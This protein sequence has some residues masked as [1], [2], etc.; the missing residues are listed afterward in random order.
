MNSMGIEV[1][2]LE[3][4]EEL[5]DFNQ[6]RSEVTRFEDFFSF[7][8]GY[9]LKSIQKNYAKR[10]FSNISF[11]I[12]A[13]TGTGKTILGIF[14]GLYN[15]FIRNKRSL[16]IFPTQLLVK[17]TFEIF[18]KY[19]PK[20][21][22]YIGSKIDPDEYL[23]FLSYESKSVKEEKIGRLLSED[24]K[25]VVITNQFLSRRF[26][27]LSS[28][29]YDYIFVD[30]L[31]SIS[32]SSKNTF[33]ILKLLGFD[34][35]T[36]NL[37][38]TSTLEITPELSKKIADLKKDIGIL[39]ISSATLRRGLNSI[40]FR[41]LLNF[42]VGSSINFV[43]NIDD[44]FVGPK[45]VEKLKEILNI[46]GPGG[47]IFTESQE[48]ALY[49]EK[50][51]QNSKFISSKNIKQIDDLVDIYVDD[52]D[53][54]EI[55]E[56]DEEI[57]DENEEEILIKESIKENE[58]NYLIGI[59]SPYSVL[60]RGLDLPYKIR[61]VVFWGLPKR[62]I[63]LKNLEN[64]RNL[65][66][67]QKMLSN[68]FFRKK[69]VSL[70]KIK[71]FVENISQPQI[72]STFII[73]DYHLYSI[74]IKT[75]LQASG[76]C[77]RITPHGITKGVSFIFDDEVFF[78]PL[79]KNAYFHNFE[80][81]R[82]NELD[83]DKSIEEINITR[84][85]NNSD[86]NNNDLDFKSYLMI[87]ESPTK[88]KQIARMFGS[89]GITKMGN[90]QVFE[91]LSP[92]GILMIVPSMGHVVEL[93]ID[94]AEEKNNIYNV[95]LEIEGNVK[96][97]K[98][99]YCFIR[100]CKECNKSFASTSDVCIYCSSKNLVSTK[101][102]INSLKTLSFF[103]DGI[104][105]A[106]DPDS[107]GEKISFDILNLLNHENYYRVIFNEITKKAIVK[108]LSEPI[109]IRKSL[110]D[111]QMVRRIEDRW[112]G[113][114]LSRILKEKM[115][116]HNISAGRVQS[117]AL[118]WIVEKYKQYNTKR[119]FAIVD[120]FKIQFIDS[121]I[122]G[123]A[124]LEIQILDEYEQKINV[125]PF[126]TS[127]ILIF[128][129]SVLK[130][131]SQETMKILQKLFEYGLITYHRT[132]SYYVSDQGISIAR[133]IFKKKN[134]DFSYRNFG[135]P[136][137][138]EAIRITKPLEPEDIK[139]AYQDKLSNYDIRMYEMIY[140]RF[141]AC[142]TRDNYVRVVKYK[143]ILKQGEKYSETEQDR[144]VQ[145]SGLGFE[146]FPYLSYKTERLKEGKYRV[147]VKT[148]RKPSTMLYSQSD[149]VK[150]MKEKEIG[151]PSTYASTIQKLFSRGYIIEKFDRLI[152]TKKGILVDEVLTKNYSEFVDEQ[153]TKELLKKIDEVEQNLKNPVSIVEELVAEIS[154]ILQLK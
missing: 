76:R 124:I 15:S 18:Q 9:K 125:L 51:I 5:I 44:V 73:K 52:E 77:S 7:C 148:V 66:P 46:M 12:V 70:E 151:R 67:I 53:R 59:A 32:K 126:N 85:R 40:L 47:L 115:E 31:D 118:H 49:L 132:E 26:E 64:Y 86:R 149:I 27:I 113:F 89:P 42:D 142:F 109:K 43:R 69:M 107:E 150:M 93:S 63:N 82:I 14:L 104:I 96:K 91:T 50:L 112:I 11:S 4:P 65:Y 154:S 84:M 2:Y 153:R 101:E 94:Q 13:P 55:E 33:R 117:P 99:L 98:T 100:K 8:F 130:I 139:I 39:V 38:K 123:E 110:V 58:I 25:F 152:P 79:S 106:T 1:V 144:I 54:I 146:I 138:H 141:L 23:F 17:Q 62:K 48:E 21:Q 10:F 102:S 22:K 74:D 87:V 45:N 75:Y 6:V 145:T 143:F 81:I 140:R 116:D 29:K 30:D 131:S 19:L 24:Q 121:E 108:S 133:E 129:N 137:A 20:V 83:I 92:I 135:E 57:L 72:I 28:S 71:N 16:L 136:H 37:A 35:E 105:L 36:L 60:V 111:A 119:T 97:V 134:F 122:K 147:K 3:K 114:S 41:K 68:I 95:I 80:I 61:Y 103:V 56:V 88:A 78:D 127:D 90:L 120:D 128:A 34:D